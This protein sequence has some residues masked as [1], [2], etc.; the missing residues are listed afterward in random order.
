MTS[1]EILTRLAVSLLLVWCLFARLPSWDAWVRNSALLSVVACGFGIMADLKGLDWG[2]FAVAVLVGGAGMVLAVRLGKKQFT[3]TMTLWPVIA[4]AVGFFAGQGMVLLAVI[5]ALFF[6]VLEGGKV[7]VDVP[8]RRT[9]PGAYLLRLKAQ[10]I[11]GVI[12]KVEGVLERLQ[13]KPFHMAVDH[14]SKEKELTIAAEFTLPTALDV[15]QL[16]AALDEIEGVI[17]FALE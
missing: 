10:S 17:Q 12:G 1:L 14:N 13:V 8:R 2:A 11:R 7:P 6:V 4:A 15:K 3:S 9:R 16:I 5:L